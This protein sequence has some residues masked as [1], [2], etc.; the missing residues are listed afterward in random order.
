MKECSHWSKIGDRDQDPLFPVVTVL[1]F[2]Y[3]SQSRLPYSVKKP[4]E[5]FIPRESERETFFF[6]HCGSSVIVQ[7]VVV[8][9]TDPLE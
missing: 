8:M 1:F 9:W 7:L 6:D 3:Q 5:G 2:L 4:L